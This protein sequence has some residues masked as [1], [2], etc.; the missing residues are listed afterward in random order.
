MPYQVLLT[1]AAH[2]SLRSF[3]KDIRKRLDREI[4]ALGENPRPHGCEKLRG[5]DALYRIRV[6][7]FRVIYEIQDEQ[8]IVL[9]VRIGD[10]KEVYRKQ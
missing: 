7:P 2:R 5:E 8:L 1:P 4:L 9:V 6:G 10:R 3:P